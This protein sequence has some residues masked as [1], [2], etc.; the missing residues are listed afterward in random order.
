MENNHVDTRCCGCSNKMFVLFGIWPAK[1]EG[2][3]RSNHFPAI[4]LFYVARK[5]P[6]RVASAA[7]K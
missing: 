7:T 5:I 1:Q 3:E 2:E 4:F 6:S